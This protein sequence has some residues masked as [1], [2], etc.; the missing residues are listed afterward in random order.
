MAII[1][2]IITI[3]ITIIIIITIFEDVHKKDFLDLRKIGEKNRE[4]DRKDFSH[5]L[6]KGLGS[7]A[8]SQVLQRGR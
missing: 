2:I 6:K 7:G 5:F 1:I 8:P 3:I 4:S